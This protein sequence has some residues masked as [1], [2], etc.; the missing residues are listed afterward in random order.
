LW[1]LPTY[2]CANFKYSFVIVSGNQH[3]N[4]NPRVTAIR[5]GLIGATGRMGTALTETLAE[6]DD[7]VLTAQ[8]RRNSDLEEFLKNDLHV[9]VDLS[10]G[11][12]VDAHGPA[13]VK[14][15]LPYIVGATG[16]KPVTLELLTGLADAADSPVL[17][18]PNFSLGANLMIRFAA[19]AS[20]LMQAPVIT[21]RHH[22]GKAD[23]P[24]GT[25][26]FTANRIAEARG[27]A[28][29]GPKDSSADFFSES[30]QGVLGHAHH[31]VA[32]HS[33]RG[34]GYLAE[35]AVQLTLPGESLT[36]EH[37]SIDRRCF[38]S[39][40]IYAIRNIGRV[41]GLVVG[42]DAILEL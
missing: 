22:M 40:I 13:V 35:Q 19:L 41:R 37:R 25:A 38:M 42:L 4:Y 23:A 5:L 12:G 28:K 6:T 3:S 33:L 26:L 15:G 1:R 18:V 8:H 14:R 17:I 27:E 29:P 16:Y 20:R 2:F 24:S 34:D 11:P 36:I 9:V 32:I 7:I 21:E 10:T 31:G 39:G 30:H